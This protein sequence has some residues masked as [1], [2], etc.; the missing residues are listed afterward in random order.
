MRKGRQRQL[1][2]NNAGHSQL[3]M[4]FMSKRFEDADSEERSDARSRHNMKGIVI[5]FANIVTQNWLSSV[6]P[7]LLTPASSGSLGIS[8]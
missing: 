3:R 7:D 8:L 4:P 5:P 6:P 1:K 2:S